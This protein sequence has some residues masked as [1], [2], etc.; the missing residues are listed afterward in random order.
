MTRRNL[1]LATVPLP[2]LAQGIKSAEIM[3]FFRRIESF[4]KPWQT[5]INHICHWPES[6]K[7]DPNL[8]YTD[9]KEFQKARKEAM[10]LF[11]LEEK[12]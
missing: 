4:D 11:D 8:G 7:C 3:D 5:F 12:K 2:L 6:E 10:P 9:N 1:V